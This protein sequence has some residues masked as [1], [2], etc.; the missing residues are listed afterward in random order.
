VP[1]IGVGVDKLLPFVEHHLLQKEPV[2]SFHLRFLI[3]Q[4][5]L[6]CMLQALPTGGRLDD[7]DAVRSHGWIAFH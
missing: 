1:L 3:L 5:E 4:E 6:F 2:I 7:E